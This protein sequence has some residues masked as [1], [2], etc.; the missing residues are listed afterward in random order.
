MLPNP[1][2]SQPQLSVELLPVETPGLLGVCVGHPALSWQAQEVQDDFLMELGKG[3]DGGWQG[4]VPG[5]E[6]HDEIYSGLVRPPT[7]RRQ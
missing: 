1:Y 2:E 3:F 4:F 5:G 6:K 7:E